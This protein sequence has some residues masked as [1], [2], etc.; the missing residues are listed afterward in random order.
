MYPMLEGVI[1][2]YDLSLY[3]CPC[4][5]NANTNLMSQLPLPPTEQE[6]VSVSCV[7]SN[8][9]DLGFYLIRACDLTP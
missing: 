8:L 5:D 4:K 3:Y 9:D 6:D 1:S 7:L 2:A